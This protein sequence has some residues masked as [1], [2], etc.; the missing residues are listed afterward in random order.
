[1]IV[2]V[3]CLVSD[4]K[5]Q[6]CFGW[7]QSTVL[8]QLRTGLFQREI[9]LM[10]D[11]FFCFFARFWLF[12]WLLMAFSWLLMAFAGFAGGIWWRLFRFSLASNAS[13]SLWR[14]DCVLVPA[15]KGQFLLCWSLWY[16]AFAGLLKVNPCFTCDVLKGKCFVSFV[17]LPYASCG[18]RFRWGFF[19]RLNGSL[20]LF[21]CHVYS[22]LFVNLSIVGEILSTCFFGICFHCGGGATPS[23]TPLPFLF[24]MGKHTAPNFNCW[25]DIDVDALFFICLW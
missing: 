9:I 7:K 15:Q 21:H 23:P 2:I 11:C 1:M 10:L 25:I 14:H 24:T 13:N 22:I 17:S 12:L 8:A 19:T 20:P 16:Y 4:G 6:V 3:S 5:W 18:G